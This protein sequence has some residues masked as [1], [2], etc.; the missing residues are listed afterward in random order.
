MAKEK[1]F[2]KIIEHLK[3]KNKILL[4]TTSNRSKYD[5]EIPKSSILAL[6]IKKQLGSKATL[7]DITKLKIYPCEGNVSNSKGNN[8]GVKECILKDKIKNPSG[9]HRC[10]ASLNN[11]DDDLWKVSKEIFNSDVVIFFGSIR[12]GQ[13]NSEY[14]KLIERLTWIENISTTL[15]EP[16]PIKDIEAGL[17]I[18]GHNWNL[19]LAKLIQKKVL[20]FFG[21]KINKKLFLTWQYTLNPYNETQD[22]YKKA[23]T[24]FKKD[25][26]I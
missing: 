12:W 5:N 3:G 6:E 4:L 1:K 14:Q 9:L 26:G 11:K 18:T 15:K 8:C 16:N 19:W 17:I 23:K 10:W 21:F 20:D 24:K 22:S 7:I 25:F 13:M 2:K